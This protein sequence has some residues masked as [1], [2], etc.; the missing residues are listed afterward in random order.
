MTGLIR[1]DVNEDKYFNGS[2][3]Y[4]TLELG[5]SSGLV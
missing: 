1:M 2:I 5:I 3:Q 4:N